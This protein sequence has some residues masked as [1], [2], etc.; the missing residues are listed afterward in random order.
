MSRLVTDLILLAK[1]RRPDFLVL[2]EVD[3]APLTRAVLAKARALG[4]RVTG[5]STRRRAGAASSTSSASPRRCS[6][7]PTTRSSTPTPVPWWPSA[8]ARGDGVVR[9]WVRDAG[10]GIAPEDRRRCSSASAAATSVPATTGSAWGSA[11]CARSPT[12]TG[13]GGD[14]RRRTARRPRWRSS[15]PS[16]GPSDD[17]R[18]EEARVGTDPDRETE[19]RSPRSWR[20]PAG[21]GAPA[22]GGRRR[23][24][25]PRRGAVRRFDLNGARPS[26]CPA[27]TA[28]RCSTSCA[29]TGSR[30]PSSCSAAARLVTDTVAALDT[31][32]TT[33][34]P[35][36]PLRGA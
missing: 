9:L 29:P 3:L 11:S 30:L 22:H 32:R 31:D 35:A 20:R 25:R 7:S 5:S 6:S 4:D 12:P 26:A 33:T 28:S 10:D 27:W 19:A 17:R 1:S 2:G 13:R 18:A 23:T 14:R 36:V 21:R 16:G 34:W 8:S 15:C 24:Q